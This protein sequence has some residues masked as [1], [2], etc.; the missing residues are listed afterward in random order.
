MFYICKI[1]ETTILRFL[2]K[3]LCFWLHKNVL[4]HYII[5]RTNIIIII[6]NLMKYF[7]MCKKFSGLY[8][9]RKWNFLL[10]CSCF[11]CF[12]FVECLVFMFLVFATLSCFFSFFLAAFAKL[13]KEIIS[14]VTSLCQSVR[15][16]VHLS[17]QSAWNNSAP[18]GRV[19]IELYIWGFFENLSRKFK[20]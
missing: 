15:L 2:L 12:V 8:S 7:K 14:S 13:L 11:F 4:F 10:L 20:H 5:I 3:L 17:C 6:T 16:S 19:F 9:K 1:Y 18:T